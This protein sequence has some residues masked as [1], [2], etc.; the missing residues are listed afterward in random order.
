MKI[1]LVE[2]QLK[3]NRVRGKKIILVTKSI[4]PGFK[5]RLRHSFFKKNNY[6]L[7]K[8]LCFARGALSANSNAEGG[9]IMR[10]N[11]LKNDCC[12]GLLK[13]LFSSRASSPKSWVNGE[14]INESGINLKSWV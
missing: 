1:D 14:D 11:K 10:K 9:G 2:E 8:S 4:I 3:L 12:L 7:Y 5:N 6:I 13:R